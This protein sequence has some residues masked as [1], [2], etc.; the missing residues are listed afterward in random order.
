MSSIKI[1]TYV[2]AGKFDEIL[3]ILKKPL[4]NLN[5]KSFINVII[6]NF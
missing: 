2:R 1:L 4:K 5:F 6:L 3:F